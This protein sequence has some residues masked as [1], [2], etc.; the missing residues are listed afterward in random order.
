MTDNSSMERIT[1]FRNLLCDKAQGFVVLANG[2]ASGF[3]L[4][5]LLIALAILGVIATF[6]IPKVLNS[7]QDGRYNATAKEFAAALS[8]AYEMYRRENPV[9]AATSFNDLTP[10]LNYVAVKTSGIYDHKYGMGTVDCSGVSVC[11]SLVNGGLVWSNNPWGE[12]GGTS[13]SDYMLVVF[14]PNGAVTESTTNGPGKGV[15]FLMYTTGRLA[16]CADTGNCPENP[17]WFTWD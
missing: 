11:L 3:T 13:S 15:E 2:K 17:P 6:T 9:T 16:T 5:E 4:A 14:D 8:G 7:Q 12:F 1:S 10:F